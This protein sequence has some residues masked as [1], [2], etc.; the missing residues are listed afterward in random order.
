MSTPSMHALRQWIMTLTSGMGTS[1]PAEVLHNF[2]RI[3]E[4]ASPRVRLAIA[5]AT[6]WAMLAA[7]LHSYARVWSTLHSLTSY[8][9][10]TVAASVRIPGSHPLQK[11]V[12]AYVV[13]QGLGRHA[14][15]LALSPA[16]RDPKQL[17]VSYMSVYD[18][19][20][21]RGGRQQQQRHA[22]PE[23][24]E[25]PAL[26]YVPQVGS[27]AFWWKGNR[28]TLRQE[29]REYEER[30]SRGKYHFVQATVADIELSC[31]C[32]FGGAGPIRDFLKFVQNIPT[33]ERTTTIYRPQN[34]AWDAG[35]VQSSSNLNAVTMNSSIKDALVK[36]LETY[37]APQTKKF[38]ANRGIPYRRGEI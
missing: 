15:T 26:S 29:S 20:H 11:Q 6:P 36:D 10:N 28:I 30:D 17:M 14:R 7:A 1:S 18:N 38:Y 4:G 3:V 31:I 5:L 13:E 27:Y 12:L 22:E 21:G 19:I 33:K 8:I 32:I 25:K 23:E 9:L 35:V 34:A 2:I 24:S 16:H 37:L